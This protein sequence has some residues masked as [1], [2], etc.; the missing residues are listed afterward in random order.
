MGNFSFQDYYSLAE[1]SA[2]RLD[3]EINDK[4]L[5]WDEVDNWR[6]RSSLVL[7]RERH[8]VVLT[9]NSALW[10]HQVLPEPPIHSA[11]TLKGK[12]IREPQNPLLRIEER[13]FSATDIWLTGN[14]G[15]TTPLRTLTDVL[16]ADEIESTLLS[17]SLRLLMLRFELTHELVERTIQNMTSIPHK[18]RALT[19]LEK[20]A[21]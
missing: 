19:R 15:V 17:D 13:T 5:L 7:G 8:P 2:L 3:G 11:S 18:R 21:I 9:V 4:L 1:L 20:L 16:K 12:R 6:S 14:Y 10:A